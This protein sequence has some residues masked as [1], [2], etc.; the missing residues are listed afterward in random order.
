MFSTFNLFLNFTLVFDLLRYS[1]RT[2]DDDDDGGDDD[3]GNGG[4]PYSRTFHLVR[5]LKEIIFFF[6]HWLGPLGKIW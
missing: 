3:D 5:Y 6:I 1:I 4:Q 2:I